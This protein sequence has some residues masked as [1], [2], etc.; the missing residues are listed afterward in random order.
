MLTKLKI[1]GFTALLLII[2]LAVAFI[3]LSGYVFAILFKTGLFII[4]ML[5][6]FFFSRK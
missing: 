1:I 5:A 3:T 2:I 6:F 4:L